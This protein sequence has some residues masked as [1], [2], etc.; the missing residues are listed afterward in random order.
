MIKLTIPC[1]SVVTVCVSRYSIVELESRIE[2][3]KQINL[4]DRGALG[5]LT[6]GSS[7]P[8]GFKIRAW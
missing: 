5:L 1:A 2:N 4:F 6:P 7:S 8:D 3:F